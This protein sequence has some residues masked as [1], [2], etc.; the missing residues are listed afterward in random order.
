VVSGDNRFVAGNSR[1]LTPAAFLK[2][3]RTHLGKTVDGDQR[4]CIKASPTE[5]LFLVAGPGTGKTTAVTLRI[6]RLVFVENM[7]P[8]AILATTFTNRAADELRSRVLGWG[9]RL[10]DGLTA[11]GQLPASLRDLD[12]NRI[13]TGTLDS[14]A[15]Q[16]LTQFREANAAPPVLIQQ[17]AADALMTHH[18]LLEQ[19]RYNS[20]SLRQHALDLNGSTGYNF[21]FREL[22]AFCSTARQRLAQDRVDLGSYRA[23]EGARNRGAL[24]LSETLNDYLAALDNELAV[25]FAG[26]EE[27]FLERLD[28]GTIDP[29]TEPLK[30]IFVDEYQDTNYL[31]ESIYF[32][33]LR[34]VLPV[35]GSLTV[36]GD[37]DQS[38][39]RFRAATVDL[40]QDF[41]H[42]CQAT[43]GV[44]PRTIYLRNNYRSTRHIVEFCNAFAGLDTSYGPARVPGKPPLIPSR[45]PPYENFPI[46]GLFRPTRQALAVDIAGVLDAIFNGTGYQIGTTAQW[47]RRNPNGSIA[48]CALL[49]GSPREYDYQFRPRLPLLLRDELRNLSQPLHIFN[50]R[51][52]AFHLVPEVEQLGGLLLECLDPGSRIQAGLRLPRDLVPVLDAWRSA[53]QSL[54]AADPPPHRPNRIGDFVND[55]QR[56]RP[57]GGGTWPEEVPVA[58]L[59]YKL[60]GWIPALVGDVE[61]LVYLEVFARTVAQSSRIVPPIVTSDVRFADGRIGRLIREIL[62]PLALGAVDVDEALLETL[63]GDQLSLFS[64]HQAKGLEFPMVIVDVGSDFPDNR[65][66]AFRRYPRT[67]GPPHIMEDHFRQYSTLAPPGRLALDRAFDDLVRQYFVAYSRPKDLLMI[68]GLGDTVDGPIRRVKNVGT[69]WTRDESAGCHWDDL[70]NTLLI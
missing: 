19:G 57:A 41:G 70:P 56:R 15:E 39:Y 13:L 50:P 31:Q 36:V 9:T 61:G 10:K 16:A 59:I 2:A 38:L 63:P 20:G 40:F 6:L 25:D 69:G 43:L 32:S 21:G 53:A 35:G 18:G 29:F 55:W 3:V 28:A 47:I 26:L 22:R 5:S 42:R 12:I 60:A 17:F 1:G 14:I 51:G 54:I 23:R 68:V 33:L 46:L 37:D 24:R 4:Q 34:T 48:D 8:A 67:G 44:S 62:A 65:P 64:V 30:A 58:E 11:A 66:A 45:L 52:V 49:C 27:A 7:D